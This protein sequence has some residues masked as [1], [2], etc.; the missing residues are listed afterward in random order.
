MPVKLHYDLISV[1]HKAP[2]LPCADV[3]ARYVR[4]CAEHNVL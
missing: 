1:N 4:V 2:N 3:N